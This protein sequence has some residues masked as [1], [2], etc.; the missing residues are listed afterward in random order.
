K[1][2]SSQFIVIRRKR[3]LRGEVAESLV[4]RRRTQPALRNGTPRRAFP[5]GLSDGAFDGALGFVFLV[6]GGYEGLSRQQQGSD[7]GGVGQGSADDLDR[8]DDAG[9]VHIDVLGGVGV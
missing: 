7:A 9:L 4:D 2:A 5:T 8:V 1:R 3:P 6:E